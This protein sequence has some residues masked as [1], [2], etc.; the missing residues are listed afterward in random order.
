M[1]R[2]H[3]V[4]RYLARAKG[5]SASIAEI[6]RALRIRGERTRVIL[7]ILRLHGRTARAVTPPGELEGPGRPAFQYQ[8]T[9]LGRQR[10]AWL[11]KQKK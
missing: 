2:Q 9:R 1:T 10:L 8:I 5:G 7:E 11:D 6:A 4:L 3:E